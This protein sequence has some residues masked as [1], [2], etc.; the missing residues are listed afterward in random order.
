MEFVIGTSLQVLLLLN[1]YGPAGN[2]LRSVKRPDTRAIFYIPVDYIDYLPNYGCRH[3]FII[4]HISRSQAFEE[5]LRK[6]QLYVSAV[7]LLVHIGTVYRAAK[8]IFE[9]GE[10]VI[11]AISVESSKEGRP[12]RRVVR[13]GTLRVL[14]IANVMKP[15]QIPKS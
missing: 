12:S 3:E 4:I 8:H 7:S 6:R 14:P 2:R 10:E 1:L 5:P 15:H 9:G 13:L 11:M